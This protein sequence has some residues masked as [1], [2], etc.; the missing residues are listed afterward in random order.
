[1]T[2]SFTGL[3]ST[4]TLAA[5]IGFLTVK[6]FYREAVNLK[7][8]NCCGPGNLSCGGKCGNCVGNCSGEC[9]HE[10]GVGQDT[11]VAEKCLN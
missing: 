3:L 4:L 10:G 11:E 7:K 1:M 8:G 9:Y 2:E 5:G 6:G